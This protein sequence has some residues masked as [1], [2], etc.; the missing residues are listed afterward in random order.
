[1]L[2]CSAVM[3]L[4]LVVKTWPVQPKLQLSLQ[5][6]PN[7]LPSFLPFLPAVGELPEQWWPVKSQVSYFSTRSLHGFTSLFDITS[8]I[9]CLYGGSCDLGRW[10]GDGTSITGLHHTFQF[11]E[12]SLFPRNS[13]N[14][15]K[16]K[17][18][19]YSCFPPCWIASSSWRRS[20][21][22]I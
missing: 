10:R 6:H 11:W 8:R 2:L 17:A 20:S 19:A 18:K 7:Q 14:R 5:L 9:C 3:F 16:Q 1:M 4:S 15:Q 12:G 21:H 22:P 13:F